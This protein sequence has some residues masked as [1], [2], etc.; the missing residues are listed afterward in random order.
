M[1]EKIELYCEKLFKII[2]ECANHGIME[3]ILRIYFNI[4]EEKLNDIEWNEIIDFLKHTYKIK[5]VEKENNRK[6]F[7]Q[8][9]YYFG[10]T[11]SKNEFVMTEIIKYLIK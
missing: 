3:D 2:S 6:F 1:K 9:S 11:I 5:I 10:S 7:S 4:T 8:G